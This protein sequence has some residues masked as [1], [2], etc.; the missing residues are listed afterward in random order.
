M[1]PILLLTANPLAI[2]I[3]APKTVRSGEPFHVVAS[4]VNRSKS[5][6]VIA[7]P[8]PGQ[9]ELGISF[10]GGL[11]RNGQRVATK[12]GGLQDV[13]SMRPWTYGTWAFKT[14][15]PGEKVKLEDV[16]Y[17]EKYVAG[18]VPET[19]PELETATRESLAAAEYELKFNYS[20][21]R[22]LDPKREK[23]SLTV[24]VIK[25]EARDLYGKTWTGKLESRA[26]VKVEPA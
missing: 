15:K 23:P 18:R 11:Y 10:G 17:Q 22:K 4:L 9:M 13:Q 2:E 8:A 24:P 25:P 26:T 14:L 3:D 16:T 21:V 1:L 6:V 7:N 19:K 12:F 5:P 20:F